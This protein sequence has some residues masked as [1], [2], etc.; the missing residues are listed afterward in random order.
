[1]KPTIQIFGIHSPGPENSLNVWSPWHFGKDWYP[2][3]SWK[4]FRSPERY[5]IWSVD[6]SR[7]PLSVFWWFPSN[8]RWCVSRCL[9]ACELRKSKKR[10]SFM[11]CQFRSSS[12]S[13]TIRPDTRCSTV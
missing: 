12:K 6:L 3:P 2:K 13:W 8:V 5:S 1:M 4:V 7:V 11:S 9:G 10:T